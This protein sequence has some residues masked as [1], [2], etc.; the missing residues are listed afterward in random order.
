MRLLYVS[1]RIGTPTCTGAS[2]QQRSR[3][4]FDIIEAFGPNGI[5][6]LPPIV[7]A[8][9]KNQFVGTRRHERNGY[10]PQVCTAFDIASSVSSGTWKGISP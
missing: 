1:I 10:V 3:P 5:F 2:A 8:R 9:D 7:V 4:K 6:E